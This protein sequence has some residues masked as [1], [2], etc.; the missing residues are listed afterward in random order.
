MKTNSVTELLKAKGIRVK[1]KPA[2]NHVEKPSPVA[3]TPKRKRLYHS[4]QEAEVQS[5]S[6]N[7]PILSSIVS[8]TDSKQVANGQQTDSNEITKTDSK[9]VA[10]R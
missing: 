3:Q 6:K 5:E 1:E 2:D 9:Q 7:S 10:N 8:K 4:P